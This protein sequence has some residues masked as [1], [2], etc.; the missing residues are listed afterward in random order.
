MKNDSS[1]S[2]RIR[3]ALRESTSQWR[4]LPNLLILGGQKCGSTSL[5]NYLIEH[6]AVRRGRTKE[7]HFFDLQ[8]ASGERWYRAQYPL[9]RRESGVICPDATPYYLFS[10]RCAE[11]AAQIVPDA[12]LIA[13]LRCP[14]ERAY[15][16][17]RHSFSRGYETRT[18]SDAIRE[19]IDR[20]DPDQPLAP[21]GGES[22]EEH[23]QQSF[24]RR[25]IYAP[26]ISAWLE[27]FPREQLLLL[28]AN[29]FFAET[30]KEMRTVTDFL[31]IAPLNRDFTKVFKKGTP[32][33][34]IEPEDETRLRDFYA[35]YNAQLVELM[36]F[37]PSWT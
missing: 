2:R 3:V 17:Y 32:G 30:G 13:L 6:P 12:K 23:R 9:S 27:H 26:Q 34:G 11:R 36:G 4:P 18:F 21:F 20:I 29:D 8:F 22:A 1:L 28:D 10:P 37:K 16:Q 24:V 15:S 7:V 33:S 35:P 25:G 14:V 31:G 5:F 19:E